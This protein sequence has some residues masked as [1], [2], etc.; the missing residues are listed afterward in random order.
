MS[1]RTLLR[2]PPLEN[3]LELPVQ[4]IIVA[5]R[6]DPV[7]NICDFRGVDP[8]DIRQTIGR[9]VIGNSLKAFDACHA[10]GK[11]RIPAAVLPLICRRVKA[12]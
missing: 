12:D 8:W 4:Q 7:W 9:A 10:S 3:P 6:E 11:T 5:T 1:V 2:T